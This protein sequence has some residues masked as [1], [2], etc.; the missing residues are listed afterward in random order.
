MVPHGSYLVNAGSADQ[1]ILKKSREA[2]LDECKRCERL[3]IP[4]YNIH[5]GLFCQVFEVTMKKFLRAKITNGCIL[6]YER[7]IKVSRQILQ[8]EYSYVVVGIVVLL[9]Q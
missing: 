1:D 4:I 9:F 8:I 6:F 3:G 2:M 7:L 5:P